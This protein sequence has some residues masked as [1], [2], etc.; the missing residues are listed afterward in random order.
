MGL[1]LPLALRVSYPDSPVALELEHIPEANLQ[2]STLTML[3]GEAAGRVLYVTGEESAAQVRLRADRIGALSDSLYLAAE[4]DFAA[5]LGHVQ[6]VEPSLLIV[7]SIQTISAA[8]VDGVPGGVT[9]VR[10]ITA[11]LTDPDYQSRVLAGL[12]A[13]VEGWRHD[14]TAQP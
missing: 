11:A 5:L 6:A 1:V 14:W 8:G 13:A 7:D 4:T 12:A 10:E 9:Q 3:G 2:G